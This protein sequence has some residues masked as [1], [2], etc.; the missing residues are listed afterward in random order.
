MCSQRRVVSAEQPVGGQQP[1]GWV[2]EEET[3]PLA[4]DWRR[5]HRGIGPRWRRWWQ[6]AEQPTSRRALSGVRR[7]VVRLPLQC[8]DMRR[9]QGVLPEKHHQ[10]RR[11][12]VQVR[13]QLR[14]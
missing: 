1:F 10:E 2:E 9:L 7:P 4:R 12:S 3:Q 5:Q 11:V 8:S 6:R 13:Q 14:N